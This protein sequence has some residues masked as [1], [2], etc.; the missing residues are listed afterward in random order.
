ME[1]GSS[2]QRTATGTLVYAKSETN[3]EIAWNTIRIPNGGEYKVVLEDGTKIWLNAASSL[4]Y[5][6]RFTGPERRV[7]LTRGEAYFE[8]AKNKEKPFIV[9]TDRMKIQALGTAFNVNLYSHSDSSVSATLTEGKVQVSEGNG[10]NHYLLPGE[11]LAVSEKVS[12]VLKAD[13]E[14]VTAWKNGLFLFN[15]TALPEVMEQLARWYDVK[16]EYAPA[17]TEKKFFTGEIKRNVPISKLLEMMELT[18]IARF[19]ITNNT[20]IIS[21]YSP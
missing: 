11:Q 16:I 18:G 4:R 5:P 7:E 20:I 15:G 12:R 2:I 10:S 9:V 13:T 17:F 3:D 6:V 19:R 21:A 1:N 14:A 8:I